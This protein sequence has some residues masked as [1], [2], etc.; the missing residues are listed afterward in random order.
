MQAYYLAAPFAV[1][2]APTAPL[3]QWKR[4]RDVS[5]AT[6]EE[7]PVKGLVFEASAALPQMAEL[8]GAACERLAAAN[9]PH[10]V[11][12]V[13]CG[14][15]AFLFPNAF[16]IAKAKGA[17]PSELLDSQVCARVLHALCGAA[18]DVPAGIADVLLPLV[19]AAVW[20][21]RLNKLCTHARPMPGQM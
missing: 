10:N 2:R 17:V 8:L 15:R 7:Y 16:S 11:F 21:A 5:V 3:P 9:V 12:V 4:R 1:E 13:D 6:L 20:T 19:S 18:E 14:Q